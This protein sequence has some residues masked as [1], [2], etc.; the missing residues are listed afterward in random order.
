MDSYDHVILGGGLA[1]LAL[2]SSLIR[3]DKRVCLIEKKHIGAGASGT[4]LGLGNP[5]TGRFGTKVWRAEACYDAVLEDMQEVQKHSEHPFFKKTGVIRPALTEKIV[6][7]M[8]ENLEK[9]DWREGWIEWLNED[10]FR[11]RF[12]GM[13]VLEGGM[14]LPVGLTVNIGQYLKTKA[15]MLRSRG[16][17]L[18]TGQTTKP[19]PDNGDFVI[20]LEDKVIRSPKVTYA[21]GYGTQN[22][23][24]WSDIDLHP[25]KG[26]IARFKA[27]GGYPYKASISALGYMG[28]LQEGEFS[29]GSTYEHHFDDLN[30][31]EYGKDYLRK[32]MA[33]VVP[34]LMHKS[35]VIGQWSGV[36][37]SAPNKKPVLGEH[38]NLPGLYL[39]SGL[40]SKGLLYSS[41]LGDMM[42]A[43]TE[44]HTDIPEELSLSR[45]Y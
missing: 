10:T 44:E 30:P 9:R 18:Y 37:M 38:K 45:F 32:R 26:Q 29:A 22:S 8:Q 17:Q 39:F 5:A 21:T 15:E 2:A 33:K 4:P 19:K 40:G 11:Q 3:R 1:G 16:L 27:E 34:G 7:R 31:D 36:R 14:W 6:R 20:R 35:E 41:Y 23:D 43:H 13:Q 24:Y 25:I 42:A 28:S 12:S